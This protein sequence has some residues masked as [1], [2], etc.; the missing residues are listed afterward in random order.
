MIDDNDM[1]KKRLKLY[2]GENVLGVFEACKPVYTIMQFF[3]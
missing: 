1:N 2:A 3:I